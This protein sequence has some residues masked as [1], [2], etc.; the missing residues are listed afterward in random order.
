[1][2]AGN[3]KYDTVLTEIEN[4]KEL[5]MSRDDGYKRGRLNSSEFVSLFK[6]IST[7]PEIYF[8]LV[9]YASNA[10]Y[11]ST[12]DLLLFLEAEQGMQRITKEKCLEVINKF[13]PSK[14]GTR[15]GH[16]GI[17]GFTY[18][19]LSEECD[20]FEPEHHTVCQDMNQPLSH[21]FIASSHNT[22]LLEDQLKGPSSVDAYIRAL[23]KG[24]RCIECELVNVDS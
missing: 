8:L 3:L 15:K 16:L 21:Y 1:M 12:D 7:R 22:Y 13:E 19:L 4:P 23:K 17:D 2:E 18:Y 5:E 6:E 11:L 10:D 14:E 20:I 9:R 24:C